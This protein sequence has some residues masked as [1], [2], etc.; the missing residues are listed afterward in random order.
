MRAFW[1]VLGALA[2]TTAGGGGIAARRGIGGGLVTI[3]RDLNTVPDIAEAIPQPVQ[4]ADGTVSYTFQ[5]RRGVLF[6]NQ[7]RQVSAEDVKYS[8]ERALN[9][10]TQS[11]IAETYL[12]DIVGAKEFAST[13]EGE[14]SGIQLD[15]AA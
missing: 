8:M 3:D 9:P 13:G 10:D 5:I 6:H 2:A 7:S 14:V 1:L 4:N 15:S 11:P 12:G